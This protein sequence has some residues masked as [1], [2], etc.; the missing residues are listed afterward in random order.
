[1]GRLTST[2][3][4]I[5]ID[6]L[7]EMT[8]PERFLTAIASLRGSKSVRILFSSQYTSDISSALS[9]RFGV[10]DPVL[11]INHSARDI[12]RFTQARAAALFEVKNELR[13]KED[14]IMRS[15]QIGAKGMFQWVN[16]AIQQLMDAEGAHD[17]RARP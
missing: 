9:S 12:H 17:V 5:I 8:S 10:T 3:T 4:S 11:I 16:L 13:E 6:N 15:L 1:M 14:V 7:E 2:P